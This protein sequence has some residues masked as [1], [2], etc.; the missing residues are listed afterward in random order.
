MA[1][2]ANQQPYGQQKQ[3]VPQYAPPMAKRPGSTATKVW[4]IILLVI[5]I[6]AAMNWLLGLASLFSGFTGTEFSP[7][8]SQ[9]AKDEIDRMSRQMI[10]AMTGRWTFWVSQVVSLVAVVLSVVAGFLLAFKPKPVGRKLALSRALFVLLLM[11]LTGYEDMKAIDHAMGMQSRAMEVSMDAEMKKQEAA[12]PKMDEATKQ[13]KREQAREITEG[14]APIM[15]GVTYGM[16]VVTVMMSLVFNGLLLFFMTRPSVKEYLEGV[17]AD[18]EEQIPGYDPS[19]GLMS[20]PPPGPPHSA[21]P[22]P[23]NQPP[24]PPEQQIPPV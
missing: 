17:A 5:G 1:G 10:D 18:G 23:G 12:N 11:P 21:Q 7:T 8:L 19:M 3:T 14:M 22:S 16:A 2:T 9:E 24:V 4:G 15:K 6:L 13:R 20:G